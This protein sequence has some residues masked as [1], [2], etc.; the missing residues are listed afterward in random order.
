[1]AYEYVYLVSGQ[2]KTGRHIWDVRAIDTV[3]I[4]KVC[5]QS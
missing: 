5:L 1:M 4:A 2:V 3:V